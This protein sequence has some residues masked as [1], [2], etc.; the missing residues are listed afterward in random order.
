MSESFSFSSGPWTIEPGES[1]RV[2]LVN[3][4]A[5]AVGEV[6][7][8]DFRNPADAALVKEAPN[9]LE[10]L[11][12]TLPILDAYRRSS[13]GDGDIAA[14]NARAVIDRATRH[15]EFTGSGKKYFAVIGRIPGD[16]EDSF[17][18]FHVATA[19]E[20]QEAFKEAIWATEAD[21]KNERE[22]VRREYGCTVFV[23]S[24]LVSD[25]P[26]TLA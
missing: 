8:A 3:N 7:Y 25:S 17:F 5:G 19:E 11:R 12:S 15:G 9:L 21:A 14:A 22:A 1:S 20:A 6:V 24:I 2:Y 23:N 13:G 4:A 18:V 16:D 10:T 26:I